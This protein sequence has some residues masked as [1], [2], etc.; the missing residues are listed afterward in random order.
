MTAKDRF[1]G[2]NVIGLRRRG[3][4]ND[5]IKQLRDAYRIIFQSGLLIK[6]AVEEVKQSCEPIPEVEEIINF[7]E[8]SA[9]RKFIRPYSSSH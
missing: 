6:N 4:S 8:G 9:K 3:F 1:E 2:L 5:T 7:F